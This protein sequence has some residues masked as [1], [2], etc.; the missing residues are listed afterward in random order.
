VPSSEA[1]MTDLSIPAEQVDPI[2]RKLPRRPARRT[3]SKKT[4]DRTVKTTPPST[5]PPP[6]GGIPTPVSTI[7]LLTPRETAKHLRT[8]ERT[9]ERRRIAGDGPPFLKI[10][11]LI[12]YPLGELETWLADR[13]QHSTSETAAPHSRKPHRTEKPK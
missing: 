12:R 1:I 13:L 2:T 4:R 9:L 8:T 11:G 3:G 7:V 5:G 10:G 6:S